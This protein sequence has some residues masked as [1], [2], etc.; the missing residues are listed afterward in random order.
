[1]I[2][3]SDNFTLSNVITIKKR[4]YLHTRVDCFFLIIFRLFPPYDSNQVLVARGDF[5]DQRE[6]KRRRETFIEKKMH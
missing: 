3:N 1:M 4:G 2:P 6:K 5:F